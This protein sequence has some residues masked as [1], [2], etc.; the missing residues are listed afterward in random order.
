MAYENL[1]VEREDNIG[2]ISLNRPPANPINLALL[3]ELDARF[4][5]SGKRTKR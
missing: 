1:N 4:S 5:P 2:I 3:D